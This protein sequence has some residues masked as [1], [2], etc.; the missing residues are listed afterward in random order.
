MERPASAWRERPAAPGRMRGEQSFCAQTCASCHCIRGVNTNTQVGPD[1][2]HFAS[3]Q[4]I[5]SG[6]LQNN[7]N[8]LRRWLTD[9]QQIKPDCHMPNFHLPE[10]DVEDL[11]AFFE[12][13]Q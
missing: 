8:D 4:T 3:R 7:A 9:P 12:T 2:T 1:L 13:L 11:T 5:G 10:D 6:V